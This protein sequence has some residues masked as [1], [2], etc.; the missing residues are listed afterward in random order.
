MAQAQ[1]S[2]QAKVSL[3]T[4]GP[5]E[6]LYSSFGHSALWIYDPIY[7]LDRA[8]SY[9]TFSF[10]EGN[11]YVK[12]L[13]GTL[14]YTISVNPLMPQFYYW[15]QENRSVKE[16]ELNLS[17]TE[18]QRLYEFLETNLLPQNREYQYKFFYDNCSTR[19]ADALKAATGDRLIFP[20]YTAETKSFRQ[21][22]DKYAYEQKPWSDFGMD[23]AIGS[24]ADEV[25]TPEQATFLP[26]NLSVAFDA[27]Q[28]KTDSTV[29]P[30]VADTRA[31]YTATPEADNGW[32]TPKIFF[33]TLAILVAFYTVWQ[34]KMER[35]NF[36]LDKILFTIVGLTGWLIVAL[37]FGTN[38]GVTASNWDILWAFP[39]WVPI[40]FMF[41][42]Y[43]KPVWL[44]WY[45]IVYGVLLLSATGNLLKH[46]YVLIPIL[47]I[48]ILRVY[49]LNNS[50]E[51][52]P[53]A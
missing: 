7:Q 50:L 11:F 31:L 52:I 43:K 5:G 37:W 46:N 34:I 30:L 23:L 6:E 44:S 25:A 27:A 39:L 35:L 1:L 4:V 28:I 38:H 40:I 51:K 24:P 41:S 53:T 22:I 45:L 17:P 47:L 32:L 18:K 20:G 3:I 36:L 19:L 2:P 9:G 16:Q 26:D 14:P 33:W 8:Y 15:Q 42:K 13:R 12:F 48:L 29:M 49:Y 21:W 10:Q